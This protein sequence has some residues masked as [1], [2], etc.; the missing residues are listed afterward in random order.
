M[1]LHVQ[2][3]QSRLARINQSCE[4]AVTNDVVFPDQGHTLRHSHTRSRSRL[5]RIPQAR[6]SRLHGL[7]L[8]FFQNAN[9]RLHRLVRS[10]ITKP[11]RSRAGIAR[12]LEA[13]SKLPF[14]R[15]LT[16]TRGL[17][18]CQVE[19]QEKSVSFSTLNVQF[20]LI[21]EQVYV[22]RLQQQW[23]ESRVPTI[24]LFRKKF[25]MLPQSRADSRSRSLG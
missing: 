12:P 14:I 15:N 17:G 3:V 13:T 25:L 9:T 18:R 6:H 19:L 1:C 2:P 8:A 21:S 20:R 5:V 4:R 11:R 10:S 23:R 24:R 16:K 7:L 22:H